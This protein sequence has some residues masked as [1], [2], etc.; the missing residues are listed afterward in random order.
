VTDFI[1][2][3]RV[4]YISYDGHSDFLETL[5]VYSGWK[6]SIYDGELGR[7]VARGEAGINA[8]CAR[9]AAEAEWREYRNAP[10]ELSAIKW[11]VLKTDV[12]EF[13][14]M[15][16]QK[17][18]SR[19]AGTQKLL[20]PKDDPQKLRQ[21]AEELKLKATSLSNEADDL[22]ARAEQIEAARKRQGAG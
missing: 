3:K 11:R 7:V 14:R 17:H 16:K 1:G 22:F 8:L 19:C 18:T 4:A 13:V 12:R 20:A 15:A 21:R 9:Q 5:R 6:W 2:R 10:P